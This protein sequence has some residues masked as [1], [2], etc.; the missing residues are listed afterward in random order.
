[1]GVESV[2]AFVH[3]PVFWWLVSIL[4]TIVVGRQLDPKLG[5]QVIGYRLARKFVS[6]HERHGVMFQEPTAA[7]DRWKRVPLAIARNHVGE[8]LSATTLDIRS[9]YYA[10]DASPGQILAAMRKVA[11]APTRSRQVV[12]LTQL[13]D[14]LHRA[15]ADRI[16]VV[17]PRAEADLARLPLPVGLPSSRVLANIIMFLAVRDLIQEGKMLGAAAYADDIV[18]VSRDLPQVGDSAASYLSRLGIID[19][20]EML[21]APSAAKLATFRVGLEKS[22]TALVRVV[23]EDE[24]PEEP[25]EPAEPTDLDPYIEADPSPEWDGVLRTVLRVPYRRERMPRAIVTALRRLVDEIRVGLDREEAANRLAELVDDLDS[26]ALVAI[27]PYWAELLVAGLASLGPSALGTLTSQFNDVAASLVPPSWASPHLVEALHFGLRT[28]WV[29][30]AAQA[31]SVT[32]GRADRDAIASE[33]AVLIDGGPIGTLHAKSIAL[34]AT[35][36]RVARLVAPDFVAS[37]LAEFSDWSGPLVGEASARS[38]SEWSRTRTVPQRRAMLMRAIGKAPR[39]VHLHEACLAVHLWMAPGSNAWLEDVGRVLRS[40]PLVDGAALDGL[41]E[42]A[43]LSMAE[44]PSDGDFSE[45]QRALRMRFA[46]PCFSVREDQLE[47]QVAAESSEVGRLAKEARSVTMRVVLEAV[48]RDADVL[49]LPEWTILPEL[50]LWAM[51][52]SAQRR[53]LLI[54][55]QTA[56]LAGKQYSN[57][58]WVGIPMTDPDGRRACL[59]PPPRPKKPL[60]PAEKQAVDAAGL[61][62]DSCLDA[63]EPVPIYSW[64]GANFASLLCYEFADAGIRTSLRGRADVITLSAVNRDWKY[65]ESAQDAMA[66]DNYCLSICVNTGRYPGTRIVR[67]TRS[68]K[69]IAAAIHGSEQPTI[70]TRVIDLEPLVAARVLNA[71]PADVLTHEPSDDLILADYKPIPP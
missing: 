71:Q 28:S 52:R 47:V 42:S 53:M 11:G 4:W 50:L 41:M 19:D 46:L 35:R 32:T 25:E 58:L 67:P 54:G 63:T 69:A 27:R 10:V 64:R 31:L 49:V 13:L 44:A 48:S 3:G 68:E 9:F 38:F 45:K 2:H 7:Y 22:S 8:T 43:R 39:F 55:G 60:S 16:S 33:D 20:S 34:Y 40:Q 66:R 26:A 30:A 17:Q 18:V 51:E 56:T 70:L 23:G 61:T 62:S 21:A 24:T 14:A 5:D 1:M 59:V 12:V 6:D 37:P 65:F 29:H 15:F 57:V 36:L